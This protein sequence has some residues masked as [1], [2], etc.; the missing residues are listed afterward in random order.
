M[1]TLN[2]LTLPEEVHGYLKWVEDETGHLIDVSYA[3]VFP[4]AKFEFKKDIKYIVIH[5]EPGLDWSLPDNVAS[6]VHEATHGYYTYKQR[7]FYPCAI[8][9]LSP[10]E[11]KCLC[12]VSSMIDDIVVDKFIQEK[13]FNPFSTIYFDVI[14][15]ET[16]AARRREDI[17]SRYNDDPIFK[18]RF[19][20]FRYVLA[21]GYLTFYCIPVNLKN[22]LGNCLEAMAKCYSKETQVAIKICGEIS[23]NNIFSIEGHRKTLEE[24]FVLYDMGDKIMLKQW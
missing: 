24:V 17:W 18:H 21:W 12:L 6:I 8:N 11:D 22:R 15:Q 19:I 1:T 4:G 20:I 2:S 10:T 5:S 13:G 3:S 14:A 9:E 16:R 7:Y 23:R